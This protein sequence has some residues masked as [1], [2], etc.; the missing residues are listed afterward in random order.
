MQNL[1][2]K[3]FIL[4]ILFFSCNK[5]TENFLAEITPQSHYEFGVSNEEAGELIITVNSSTE[6]T[7][8]DIEGRESVVLT[9]YVDGEYNQDIVLF[10]GK[11]GF[12]YSFITGPLSPGSHEVILEYSVEKS[13]A[14]DSKIIIYSV[15]SGV[16]SEEYTKYSPV[17]YGRPDTLR[18]EPLNS[19]S[20]TGLLMFVEE[21]KNGTNTIYTYSM[22]WSNEDGGTGVIPPLLMAQYGRTTDIEWVYEVELD[23]GKNIVSERFQK[24]THTTLDFTGEKIGMHPLLVV[25]SNNNNM[26]QDVSSIDLKT[27]IRYALVPLYVSGLKAREE[28]M[29]ANPWTYRIADQEMKRETLLGLPK[30]ENPGDPLTPALSD[31]RNYLFL[32]FNLNSTADVKW[33]FGAEINGVWYYSDHSL[34]SYKYSGNG[35]GRSAIELPE[36][37]TLDDVSRLSV[38]VSGLTDGEDAEID[39]LSAFMLDDGFVPSNPVVYLEERKTLTPDVQVIYFQ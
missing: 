29:D 21:R 39:Y 25:A 11:E 1:F 18:E 16:A 22:I 19:Y 36:G 37:S 20:D 30:M 31:Y 3:I 14:K 8:W 7:S 28:L 9:V 38:E 17:L 4:F 5:K 34:D 15:N 10:S 6:S 12:D 33:R 27:N 24:V 23:S 13:P 32:Q 35:Y 2:T 26:E